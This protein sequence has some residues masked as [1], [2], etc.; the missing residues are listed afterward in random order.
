V[1]VMTEDPDLR[2]NRIALLQ[3]ISNLYRR[4]ADFSALQMEL[5]DL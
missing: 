5:G 1:L 4:I 3:R 2:N